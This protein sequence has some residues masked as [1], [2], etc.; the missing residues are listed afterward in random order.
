MANYL[1]LRF[2]LLTVE[3]TQKYSGLLI[4][5]F[6]FHFRSINY[7]FL[8]SKHF[9]GIINLFATVMP[10]IAEVILKKG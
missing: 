6:N 4:I 9:L 10:E 5:V 3:E 8:I 7:L 1:I 2:K